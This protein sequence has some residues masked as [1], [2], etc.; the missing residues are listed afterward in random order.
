[1]TA[2]LMFLITIY[3]SQQLSQKVDRLSLSGSSN[4]ATKESQS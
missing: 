1:V 4:R 2:I 3:D